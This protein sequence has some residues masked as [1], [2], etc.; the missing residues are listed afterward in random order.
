MT[1]A[2]LTG[3]IVTDGYDDEMLYLTRY[4]SSEG[5]TRTEAVA[6][7]FASAEEFKAFQRAVERYGRKKGWIKKAT[8]KKAT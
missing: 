4:W 6:L 1:L 5:N 8:R 2:R 7:A 3:T